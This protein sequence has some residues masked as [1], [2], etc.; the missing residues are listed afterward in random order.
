M[1]LCRVFFGKRETERVYF[2]I[3]YYNMTYIMSEA[4]AGLPEKAKAHRAGHSLLSP[5][6]INS[7]NKA[8]RMQCIRERENNVHIKHTTNYKHKNL[9]KL[10]NY[11]GELDSTM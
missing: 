8:C 6:Q 7:T 9:T 5:Q 4:K 2:S 1:R 11:K 10:L 3:T